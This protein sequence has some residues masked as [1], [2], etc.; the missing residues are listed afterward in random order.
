M[1]ILSDPDHMCKSHRLAGMRGIPS[2]RNTKGSYLLFAALKPDANIDLEM[3]RMIA[4]LSHTAEAAKLAVVNFFPVE[5]GRNVAL[6]P[7]HA[8]FTASKEGESELFC[9]IFAFRF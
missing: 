9:C 7:F 1:H 6:F 8:H 2:T 5:A 4:I 3:E